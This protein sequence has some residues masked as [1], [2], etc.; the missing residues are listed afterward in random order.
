VLLFVG[1]AEYQAGDPCTMRY[2][3]TVEESET[4]VRVAIHGERP[5]GRAVC[6]LLG[7]WRSVTVDLSQPF[8]DRELIVFGAPRDV[9]NGSTLAQP[10]W[11]PDGWQEGHEQPAG[12]GA[13]PSASWSRTWAPPQP[14]PRDGACV[15]GKSGFILF[16]GAPGI[17]DEFPPEPGETVIDTFDVDGATATYSTQDALGIARLAWTISNQGFV[18]K[19]SP[20]CAGDEPPTIE[21]MLRFARNLDT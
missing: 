9:F 21:T 6:R 20:A 18:L 16:Q 13:G 17:V 3:A 8:G 5:P 11:T 14:E 12:L 1:A 4:E 19:S 7:H 15:P 2:V 10:R